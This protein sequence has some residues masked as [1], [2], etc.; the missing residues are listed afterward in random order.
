MPILFISF[1]LDLQPMEEQ[2]L[3]NPNNMD[4]VDRDVVALYK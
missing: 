1:V 3:L 2:L 4:R